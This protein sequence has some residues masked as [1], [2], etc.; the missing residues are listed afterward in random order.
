M[1]HTGK[2]SLITAKTSQK[3]HLQCMFDLRMFPFETLK[4]D[5]SAMLDQDQLWDKKNVIIKRTTFMHNP[6][7]VSPL[8]NCLYIIPNKYFKISYINISSSKYYSLYLFSCWNCKLLKLRL[9]FINVY[10]IIHVFQISELDEGKILKNIC[11]YHK[12]S[13][14]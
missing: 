14:F 7:I 8:M 11:K 5:M 10:W 4:C 9:K 13:K 2:Q 1:L 12:T 6:Y 3:V